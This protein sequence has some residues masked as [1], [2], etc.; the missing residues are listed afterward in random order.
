[1]CI[2]VFTFDEFYIL[3]FVYQAFRRQ[4]YPLTYHSQNR[5]AEGSHYPGQALNKVPCPTV[6]SDFY[7]IAVARFEPGTSWVRLIHFTK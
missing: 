4:S 5:R 2:K 6:Q 1:M 3:K 7:Q